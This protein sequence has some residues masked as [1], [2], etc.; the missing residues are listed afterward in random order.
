MGRLLTLRQ[1]AE[2]LAISTRHLRR[3]AAAGQIRTV[4]LG[5]C[6]R[7]PASEVERLAGDASDADR[8]RPRSGGEAIMQ[9]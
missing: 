6:L 5:R 3:L 2:A 1:A 7:V 8:S 4:R 9:K